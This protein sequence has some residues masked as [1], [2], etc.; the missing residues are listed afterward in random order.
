MAQLSPEIIALLQGLA[1]Q[2]QQAQLAP[3]VVQ[4]GGPLQPIARQQVG[5]QPSQAMAQLLANPATLPQGG[6][7]GGLGDLLP[8]LALSNA[9]KKKTREQEQ[10]EEAALQVASGFLQGQVPPSGPKPSNFNN[11]GGRF[12]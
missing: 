12:L 1:N 9:L 4:Q 3:Q 10:T 11:P 8:Q 5:A 6:A 2:Q 7:G